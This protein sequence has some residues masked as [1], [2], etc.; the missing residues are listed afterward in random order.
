MGAYCTL[1][2][3]L[4]AMDEQD[5][6]QFSNDGVIDPEDPE[7]DTDVIDAIIASA[8]SVIDAYIAGR[9][10]ANLTDPP[11]LV[12][13]MAV[14]ISLYKLTSRKGDAPDEYR[15]RYEYAVKLL[16]R[17]ADGKAD[18]PGVVRDEDTDTESG[19][20]DGTA[21]VVSQTA[22]Y[23]GSGTGLVGF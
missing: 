13:S 10:G 23:S 6:I 18:I 19:S 1:N 17:I 8:G 20:D 22:V 15:R 7:P 3:I 12:V 16:E 11:D 9:Y 14:D 4:N 2:D 21:A 5:V